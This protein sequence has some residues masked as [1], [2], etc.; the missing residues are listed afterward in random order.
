[1]AKDEIIFGPDE[2]AQPRRK[3]FLTTE[4]QRQISSVIQDGSRGKAD[5]E[6]LGLEFPYCHPV[7][8]YIELLG[9]GAPNSKAVILDF[10]AGSGTNGHATIALNREEKSKRKF[11]LVEIGE[12]FDTVLKPRIQKVIYC[13][14][15]KDGKPTSR[16]SGVSHL[17]KYFRLESYEDALDNISFETADAQTILQ[18]E[19]YVLSYMLDFETKPPEFLS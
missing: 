13:D 14:D 15:W 7:S 6:K 11:I 17:F 8:L 19:D 3:V 5:V 1:M 12:H 9:A 10:F 18:L 2:R 16:D 4:S